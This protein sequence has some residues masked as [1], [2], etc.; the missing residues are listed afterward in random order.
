MAGHVGDRHRHL[1]VAE[2]HEVVVVAAGFV[3]GLIPA[4]NVEACKGDAV[5]RQES[6]LD[7]WGDGEIALD[8]LLL[9]DRLGFAW[10][11]Q[12][13]FCKSGW[14]LPEASVAS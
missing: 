4:G 14:V 13:S 11:V 10:L 3:C 5:L 7:F 2:R 9:D 8:S 1:V 12:H 6:T